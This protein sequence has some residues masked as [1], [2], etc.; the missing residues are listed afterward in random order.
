MTMGNT[1]ELNISS[2]RQILRSVMLYA[3][4]LWNSIDWDK[5]WS[6]TLK[7][8]WLYVKTKVKEYKMLSKGKTITVKELNRLLIVSETPVEFGYYKKDGSFRIF[9][10]TKNFDII[11]PR[12]YPMGIMNAS[13]LRFF[14]FVANGWRG[15]STNTQNVYIL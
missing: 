3:N 6:D 2:H 8:S 7:T 12:H 4:F 15:L 1:F 9:N 5:T 10:G 14:D 11:P 13:N